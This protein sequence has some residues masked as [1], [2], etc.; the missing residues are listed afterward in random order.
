MQGLYLVHL[1]T[2]TVP[3]TNYYDNEN[4]N[5]EEDDPPPPHRLESRET[6]YM[7]VSM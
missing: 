4:E 7:P 2:F 1:L 5:N 6:D 3:G